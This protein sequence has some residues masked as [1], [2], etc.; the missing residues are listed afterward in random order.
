MAEQYLNW[1]TLDARDHAILNAIAASGS[2]PTGG[3]IASAIG[4]ASV[5]VLKKLRTLKAFNVVTAARV[6]RTL[7][8]SLDADFA[9][10]T[11][12]DTP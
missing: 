2:A 3:Q 1:N 12:A 11:E 6:G 10:P 7:Y 8:W 4:V 9:M 5:S